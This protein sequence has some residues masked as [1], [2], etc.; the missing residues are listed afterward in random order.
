MHILLNF[1]IFFLFAS[2]CVRT[3]RGLT[4]WI[5]KEIFKWFK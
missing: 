1:I 3:F 4:S 5:V 2:G